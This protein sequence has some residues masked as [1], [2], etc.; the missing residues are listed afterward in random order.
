MLVGARE[1]SI[2]VNNKLGCKRRAGG[3]GRGRDTWVPIHN[4][5]AVRPKRGE[6][7]REE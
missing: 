2:V 5:A 7:R 1:P 3:R 6:L 4:A